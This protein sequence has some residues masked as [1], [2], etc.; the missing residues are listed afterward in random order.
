MQKL[1]FAAMAASLL[2]AA[3][4]ASAHETE[5]PE[6]ALRPEAVETPFA[7]PVLVA[8]ADHADAFHAEPVSCTISAR[9]TPAALLVEARAF[10]HESIDGE[11]ELVITKSGGG[12]SADI[13]QGGPLTLEPGESATLGQNEISIER[14]AR[15]RA[16]LTI[17]DAGGEICRRTFR[18]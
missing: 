14:G 5:V 4:S 13:R 12:S 6:A 1:A 10:A 2:L 16:V 17:S 11:Y 9:R 7:A 15:T 18:T 3:C 8:A